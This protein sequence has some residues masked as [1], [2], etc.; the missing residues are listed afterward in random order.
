MKIKLSKLTIFSF[1]FEGTLFKLG[2]PLQTFPL[3]H[4]ILIPF[5]SK[6]LSKIVLT[7]MSKILFFIF[8]YTTL[9]SLFLLFYEVIFLDSDERIYFFLRQFVSFL[10]GIIFFIFLRYLFL[11]HNNQKIFSTILKTIY[12]ILPF[13]IFDIATNASRVMGPFSEPSHLAQYLAFIIIPTIMLHYRYLSKKNLYLLVFIISIVAVL[14][15]SSTFFIR[16]FL[17][18]I[19]LAI[20]SRSIIIKFL[21]I[22][23]IALFVLI[24][25]YLLP[26]LFEGNYITHMIGIT[27]N[28]S[29]E[30]GQQSGSLIDRGSFFI[31]LYQLF[32]TMNFNIM[33][34]IGYGFGGDTLYYT[35]FI[36]EE[37]AI[38]ILKFKNFYSTT[39]FAG[40]IFIFSGIFGFCIY[41]YFV[42]I[43]FRVVNKVFNNPYII[44]SI[45]FAVFMYTTFGLGPFTF[46]EFWFWLAYVDSRYI[47][48][49]RNDFIYNS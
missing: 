30:G 18:F 9:V 37:I 45:L 16:L 1:P 19:G 46:L 24:L 32:S 5:Y 35:N 17:I 13:V 49:R 36:P 8:T 21:V 3:T 33:T 6:F 27:I 41:L 25:L 39:S 34:F 2:L 10:L 15:F 40:K 31:M 43:T 20:F 47:L 29:T 22:F 14:S 28:A 11:K 38:V 12:I 26:I 7:P 23:V 44:K 4:F 42:L 48:K